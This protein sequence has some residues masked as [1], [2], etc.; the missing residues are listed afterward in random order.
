[1]IEAEGETSYL[2]AGDRLASGG[3]NPVLRG[4]NPNPFNPV[5]EVTYWVP[6][7]SHV[8]VTIYNVAGRFVTRLVDDV[9]DRGEHSVVWRADTLPSGVYFCRLEVGE[10]SDHRKVMLLK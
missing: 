3:N 9:R 4:A 10:Y 6:Q 2:G 5:T 8:R 7:K 1:M